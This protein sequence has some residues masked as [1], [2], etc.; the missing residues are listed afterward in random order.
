[1][2]AES[3]ED[4][5]EGKDKMMPVHTKSRTLMLTCICL[6]SLASLHCGRGDRRHADGSTLTV[7]HRSDWHLLFTPDR[8]P[9]ERR[10]SMTWA[11]RLKRVF[12]IDIETCS[13]CGGAV[14]L[15]ASIED[16]V[17]IKKILAHLEQPC[18]HFQCL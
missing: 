15:I 9:A 8:T 6:I 4:K 10:A 7:L 11:Q 5:R 3:R 13:A 12:N 16:P 2:K 18:R 14:K 17:V 1:M